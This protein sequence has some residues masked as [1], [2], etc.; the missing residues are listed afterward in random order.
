MISNICLKIIVIIRVMLSLWRKAPGMFST[1]NRCV[2]MMGNDGHIKDDKKVKVSFEMS[3]EEQYIKRKE[4]EELETLRKELN[5]L[6]KDVEK[7]KKND[8]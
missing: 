4:S 6:K 7:L 2:R 8:D 5:K 1:A 3:L